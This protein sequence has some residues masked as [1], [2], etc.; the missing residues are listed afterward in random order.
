MFYANGRIN[1]FNSFQDNIGNFVYFS[2]LLSYFLI[3][4][5]MFGYNFRQ[6][7]PHISTY[8]PVCLLFPHLPISNPLPPGVMMSAPF[9]PLICHRIMKGCI[10]RR[11]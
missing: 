9:L 11:E 3:Q 7:I 6:A 2:W 4:I 10:E 5:F 1:K 8:N